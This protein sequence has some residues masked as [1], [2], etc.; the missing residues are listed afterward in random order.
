MLHERNNVVAALFEEGVEAEFFGSEEE[1]LAK[2]RHYLANP[3]E[4]QRIAEAGRRRCER[5]GYS[6][7]DRVREIV[8]ALAEALRARRRGSPPETTHPAGDGRR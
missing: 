1:L 6:E 4:R 3:E 5:S 8:P 7:V 2:C